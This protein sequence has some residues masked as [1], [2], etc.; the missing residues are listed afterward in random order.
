LLT[1]LLSL[2]KHDTHLF[3]STA[4]TDHCLHYLLPE[5]TQSFNESQAQ[6]TEDTN[7]HLRVSHIRTTQLKNTFVN[8]CLFSMV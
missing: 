1:Y 5:K 4:Y 8:K 6:A 7:T 3:R 2:D